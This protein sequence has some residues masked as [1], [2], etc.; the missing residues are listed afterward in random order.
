MTRFS[1]LGF[2]STAV[3]ARARCLGVLV[4]FVSIILSPRAFAA[5]PMCDPSGASIAAPT[6][7]LPNATGELVAPKSC[8]DS[9]AALVFAGSAKPARDTSSA[10]RIA[11]SA[12]RVLPVAYVFP[13]CA[14]ERL[15][16]VSIRPPEI[17]PGFS[18][19][20]YRPPRG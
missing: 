18:D 16:V 1:R 19:P 9:D 10:T 2:S 15:P 13:D 7:A 4:A 8:D 5:A 6:P 3:V 17:R 20:V 12:P 14:G 11:P